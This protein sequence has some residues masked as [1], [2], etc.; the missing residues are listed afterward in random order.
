MQ[1]LAVVFEYI[2]PINQTHENWPYDNDYEEYSIT[3]INM[4]STTWHIIDETCMYTYAAYKYP[5]AD[6]HHTSSS[7]QIDHR[8]ECFQFRLVL[9]S[10]IFFAKISERCD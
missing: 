7:F 8:A 2:K 9:N 3:L 4:R 1:F 10:E 6:N 5:F